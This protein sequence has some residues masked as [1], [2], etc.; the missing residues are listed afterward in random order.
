MYGEVVVNTKDAILVLEAGPGY[1]TQFTKAAGLE[2]YDETKRKW[3]TVKDEDM[4]FGYLSRR[5]YRC[6]DRYFKFF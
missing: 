5:I 2:I 1:T 6:G 3:V 4:E